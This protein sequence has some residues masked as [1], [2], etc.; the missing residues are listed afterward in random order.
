MSTLLQTLERTLLR[1]LGRRFERRYL[2]LATE[3]FA[4][5]HPRWYASLFDE[6]LLAQPAAVA[7][8][9]RRDATAL[10]QA[11]HAQFGVRGAVGAEV[12]SVAVDFLALVAAAERELDRPRAAPTV[13]AQPTG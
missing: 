7:A 8:V 3:R 12:R 2:R 6:T 4:Q 9:T 5:L 10:A 11:W 13:A 1:S